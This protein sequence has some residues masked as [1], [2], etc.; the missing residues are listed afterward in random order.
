M[1]LPTPHIR[2]RVSDT[3]LAR[4]LRTW[5]RPISPSPSCA[6]WLPS[7]PQNATYPAGSTHAR[8]DCSSSIASSWLHHLLRCQSRPHTRPLYCSLPEGGMG[9]GGV[10]LRI[11]FS[12]WD[13]IIGAD[14]TWVVMYAGCG[15]GMCSRTVA[16]PLSNKN[17]TPPLSASRNL[18]WGGPHKNKY[19]KTFVLVD[20]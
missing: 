4:R 14:K 3:P 17:P 9:Q 7:Y 5:S 13:W 16:P 10:L 18:W 19:L 11:K 15:A 12:S 2:S 6:S 1:P 20:L 8:G